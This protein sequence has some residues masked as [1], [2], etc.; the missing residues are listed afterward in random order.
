MR[1][2]IDSPQTNLDRYIVMYAIASP[3]LGR[4]I[5]GVYNRSGGANRGDIR[6][7]M[8][9]VAGV[10]LTVLCAVVLA[11]TFIPKGAIRFNPKMINGEELDKD[12]LDDVDFMEKERESCRSSVANVPDGKEYD[13]VQIYVSVQVR[14]WPR[15][16]CR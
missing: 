6:P 12:L 13:P 7:A 16:G 5:D 11:S 10:Q 1:L 9:N 4:Y 2:A 14:G 15:D 3:L 8:R